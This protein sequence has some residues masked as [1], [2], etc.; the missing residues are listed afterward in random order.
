MNIYQVKEVTSYTAI[1]YYG[2]EE[3]RPALR[4]VPIKTGKSWDKG[5]SRML[6][7]LERTVRVELTEEELS[8]L[9][10]GG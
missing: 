8:D 10:W 2:E 5:N 7:S 9:V 6:K 4:V 1:P 3:L